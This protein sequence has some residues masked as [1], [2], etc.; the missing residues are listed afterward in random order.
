[1]KKTN[2]MKKGAFWFEK[3]KVY[4]DTNEFD[5]QIHKYEGKGRKKKKKLERQ[6]Q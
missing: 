2:N 1:M 3:K 5:T 6:S 4:S